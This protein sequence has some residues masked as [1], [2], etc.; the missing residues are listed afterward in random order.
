MLE[1][2]VRFDSLSTIFA[3][4]RT[5]LP[6]EIRSARRLV[7][8][9]FYKQRNPSR[10]YDRNSEGNGGGDG[11]GDGDGGG[12]G[13]GDGE[14]GI[15]IVLFPHHLF[16]LHPSFDAVVNG[17]LLA[18]RPV[19]GVEIVLVFLGDPNTSSP[20]SSTAP[21]SSTSAWSRI[22]QARINRSVREA[23]KAAHTTLQQQ[24]QQQQQ[25]EEEEQRPKPKTVH[26]SKQP[27]DPT[28]G[29]DGTVEDAIRRI[30]WLPRQGRAE[31]L[32]LLAAADVIADSFPVGGGIVS[33]EALAQC[34]PVVTWP[35]AM[36]TRRFTAGMIHQ[37]AAAR[38][39]RGDID[40]D[41]TYQQQRDDGDDGGGNGMMIVG[42][43]A[44]G[45]A[46]ARESG[47]EEEEEEKDGEEVGED[48]LLRK[49]CLVSSVDEYVAS[50]VALA[51]SD[52]LRRSVRARICARAANRLFGDVAGASA[53]GEWESFLRRAHRTTTGRTAAERVP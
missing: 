45:E 32:A 41:Y 5:A 29:E 2:L 23:W 51:A 22:L 25:E 9:A 43:A 49:W 50:V 24:Q 46:G 27:A 39:R 30:V 17:I 4:P 33:F 1:Q 42:G 18:A 40:S 21:A 52:A 53:V 26:H 10:Y 20:A 6:G 8:D 31:F 16:K 12:G 14:D 38:R 19:S 35:A 28:G 3:R 13:G 15:R 48:V 7:V 34:T 44:G 37:L 47:R 11:D 36:T